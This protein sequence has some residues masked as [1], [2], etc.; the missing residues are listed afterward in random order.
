MPL[1]TERRGRLFVRYIRPYILS[2][3][4]HAD[5]PAPRAAAAAAMDRVDAMCAD[6]DVPPVDAA[7]TGRH[8]VREQLPRAPRPRRLHRRPGRRARSATSSA[9]GWRPTCSPTTTSP[10]RSGSPPPPRRGGRRRQRHRVIRAPTPRSCL[11]VLLGPVGVLR[12]RRAPLRWPTTTSTHRR[13]RAGAGADR[14]PLR[15]GRGL[16]AGRARRRHRL[17]EVTGLDVDGTVLPGPVPLG[18]ARG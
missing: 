5:A 3:R 11:A 7:R 18:V 9:S 13:R 4:R 8:A 17:Q 2:A 10:R 6:P 16:R 15:A 14:R 12:R 1:F